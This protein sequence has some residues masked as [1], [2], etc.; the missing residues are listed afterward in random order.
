MRALSLWQPWASL[1]ALGV[2]TIETRGWSTAYR[3][4]LL[5]ASTRSA[6][7]PLSFAV[8]LLAVSEADAPLTVTLKG[9]PVG[10]ALAVATLVDVVP[11]TTTLTRG[12]GRLE[13]GRFVW[14]LPEQ[15]PFGDFSPGR[16]AWL[17]ADIE[18]LPTPV[19]VRGRQGLWV[20]DANLV[21]QIGRAA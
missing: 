16:F 21:R 7:V 17:L 10:M 11:T 13:S 6:P 20:P 4:P 8:P 5:I 9:L 15:A 19:P 18:P 14:R 1:I 2:K 3:G 12:G